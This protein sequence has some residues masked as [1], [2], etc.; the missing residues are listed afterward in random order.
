[1]YLTFRILNFPDLTVDGSFTT[2]AAVA[3]VCLS[4]EMNPVLA[5]LLAFAAGMVAGAITGLLHTYGKIDGLLAGILTMIALWSVNL[6]IMGLSNGTPALSNVGIRS[7]ESA[8]SGLREADLLGTW[9]SVGILF[10]AVFVLK[11]IIDWFLATDLGLAIQAT[12]NNEQMIRSFGVNT[13]GMKILTLALSNGLVALGGALVAQYTGSADISMGVG[14]ILI[15]LASVILG[16][17]FFGNRWVWLASFGVIV[18]AVLYRLV[19]YAALT[20]GLSNTDVRLITAVIV[21]IALLIPR[22]GIGKRLG[23]N[24]MIRGKQSQP[25]T[26]AEPVT[27]GQ[28]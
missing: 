14:L 9:G 5:M 26:Q 15:G 6:R 22:F 21:V 28:R 25:A 19:I 1:V 24:R 3:A 18:G 8:F 27:E 10:L 12:G 11:L 20:A 23:L 16:Q 17:A 13:D 4:H 7:S 2:G